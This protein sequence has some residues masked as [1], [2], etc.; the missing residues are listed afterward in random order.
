MLRGMP[1]ERSR[2][3]LANLLDLFGDRWTLLL[4]RDLLLFEKHRFSELEAS[5]EAI[6]TNVLADRLERLRAAHVV[7]RRRYQRHPPRYEY[8][9][10]QRGREL[11][12]VLREMAVWA[13]RHLPG[14]HRIPDGMAAKLGERRPEG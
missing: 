9:L 10:T 11:G 7:S 13:N 2:C 5:G 8:H 4:V 1:F 6:P 14:T 3:P 12:P